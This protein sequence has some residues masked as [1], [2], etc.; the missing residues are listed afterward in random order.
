M[1]WDRH[2]EIESL[3]AITALIGRSLSPEDLL[4][5]SLSIKL[6]FKKKITEDYLKK[7]E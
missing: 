4:S 6:H 2:M 3:A 1:I 7:M 5:G